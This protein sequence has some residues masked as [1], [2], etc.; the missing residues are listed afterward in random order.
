MK[1]GSLGIVAGVFLLLLVGGCEQFG[2]KDTAGATEGP[3]V[4][5]TS[6]LDIAFAEQEPPDRVLDDGQQ[7]FF[8]TL[9]VKN[10]GEFT[11]PEGGLIASL[12]GISRTAFGLASL[13]VVND[14]AIPGVSKDL[15]RAAEGLIEF[16][17]AGFQ[18]DIPA[19]FSTV[20]QADVCY[21]YQTS[22]IANLCLKKD[23]LRKGVADVCVPD[24]GPLQTSNSGGPLQVRSIEER[25]IGKNRIK[26]TITLENAGIG[27]VYAP[28]TYSSVC[29]GG[30]EG[31]DKVLVT[32]SNPEDAFL[33]AC[34]T[35]GGS[36]SGT[37]RLV[38]KMKDVVCTIDT[39]GMQ[40]AAFSDIL[41][42]TLDYQYRDAVRVPLIVENAL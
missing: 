14:F 36:N 8:I 15:P 29:S 3:F 6:G 30:D 35:F 9:L 10:L 42:V 25:A 23:V 32:L 13:D 28:S 33:V 41:V 26:V 40:D 17:E 38:N 27:G 19:D 39:D 12:S 16:G 18:H 20:L 24:V 31:M 1:R 22:A 7:S 21:D 4:G 37:I 2:G 34:S 5:G 11:I